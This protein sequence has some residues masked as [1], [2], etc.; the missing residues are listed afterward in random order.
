VNASFNDMENDMKTLATT[1]GL[2]LTLAAG[3]AFADRWD[4]DDERRFRWVPVSGTGIHYFSTA[5]IHSTR[6]TRRG[7]VI[8]STDIIELDGDLVGK[9]LYHPR[10]VINNEAG[11]LVNTG[12]Q[13]FSGTVLGSF[14]VMLYDNE[15]RF[16]V[17]L[18]TGET[19]GHVFL[20]DRIAGPRIRCELTIIG[21]GFDEN[22]DG[23]AE[24]TGR[25]KMPVSRKGG[26]RNRD[27]D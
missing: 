16:E 4:D 24:Y 10:T 25:C 23:L 1:L 2:L 18:F 6:P 20:D 27:D 3:F 14:P 22:E 5:D 26:R 7:V 17:N 11:T 9:V 21:T 13:V 15:F 8:R 12:H 19:V